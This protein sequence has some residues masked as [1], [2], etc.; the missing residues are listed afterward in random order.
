M[1]YYKMMTDVTNDRD[2][3][4]YLSVDYEI[5]QYELQIGKPFDNS[6]R[7]IIFYY[8]SD[9]GD[10]FTDYLSND[11]GWFLVSEKLKNILNNLDIDIQYF[12]VD[13]FE[14]KESVS[15]CK[16]Y[17]ANI[18]TVV[19][20]LCLEESTYFET[21]LDENEIIYS[22]SRYAVYGEKLKNIDIFKLSNGQE[23]PIFVSEKF[24]KIIEDNKLTGL[25]FM[26]IEVV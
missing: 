21:E 2:I 14:K 1:K 18:L 12:E 20:A 11:M 7:N 22:I 5:E 24:K 16:Y 6:N 15:K 17:I 4:C 8:K 13:I 26:E 23:I 9:E 3:I 10:F 25:D 19:D